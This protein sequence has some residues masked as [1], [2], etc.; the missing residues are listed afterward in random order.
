MKTLYKV[1]IE[2]VKDPITLINVNEYDIEEEDE[3]QAINKA[4]F[5]NTKDLFKQFNTVSRFNI[6]KVEKYFKIN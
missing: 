1:T 6:I 5:F 2:N 4:I 3:G